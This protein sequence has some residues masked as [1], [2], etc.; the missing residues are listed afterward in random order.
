MSLPGLLKATVSLI[1]CIVVSGSMY[2]AALAAEPHE[3]P[4]TAKQAFNGVSLLQYY[5]D[6]LHFVSSK[7]PEEVK[8]RLD[9]IPFVN[10][11]L[12]MKES[13]D[14]FTAASLDLAW[15]LLDIDQNLSLMRQL[16]EEDSPVEVVSQGFRTYG[17]LVSAR[18][19]V[20]WATE[21]VDTTGRL[22]NV[23]S[24]PV[25]SDLRKTYDEVMGAVA[26]NVRETLDL[27]ES[28]LADMMLGTVSAEII[29]QILEEQEIDVDFTL[30]QP[31]ISHI[32]DEWN[33]AVDFQSSPEVLVETLEK[34]AATIDLSGVLTAESLLPTDVTLKIDRQAAYV[35]ENIHFEG[36]L[37]SE[38][39]ALA[40]RDIDILLNGFPWMTT[41]TETNGN[42]E[43]ILSVPY[44]Y[45][46]DVNV[47]VLFYP[48]GEDVNRYISSYSPEV[49]LGLLFYNTQL[50]VKVEDM[51][52]PGL[53]TTV[54]GEFD[55]GPSPPP[56]ERRAEIY[57]DDVLISEFDTGKEFSQNIRIPPELDAGEHV[58]TISAEATGRY[59]PVVAS[60]VLNITKVA[61]ILD[62]DTPTI[63]VVPGAIKL[64]GRIY[65]DLSPPTDTSII[66]E[67]NKSEVELNISQDGTFDT[68]IGVGMGLGL[69]GSQELTVRVIPQ[70]PWHRSFTARR[71]I[72]TINAVNCGAILVLLAVLGIL[73]P[74]ISRGRVRAP[75][76]MTISPEPDA[77]HEQQRESTTLAVF[78]ENNDGNEGDPRSRAFRWYL[79][80]VRLVQRVTGFLP[81]PQQTLREFARETS[82]VLGPTGKYFQELTGIVERL[83]YS[84]QTATE[85]DA[86]KSKQLCKGIEDGLEGDSG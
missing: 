10:I 9:K 13:A 77:Y 29:A 51:A 35:G 42:Y 39:E 79:L 14:D 58:L 33:V 80:A 27:N 45:F 8:A 5:A 63:L 69:I 56:E 6:A 15:L 30:L 3:D 4:E 19:R 74:R 81:R 85:E 25:E 11:P 47:Q 36:M 44:R 18:E 32:F 71:N 41:T 26:D 65:S 12:G 61:P 64:K 43:D 23:P 78:P 34:L 2:T 49:R 16:L 57:L 20:D 83:L 28:I 22:L 40:G 86:E 66:M 37:T 48:R 38:G 21:V 84:H 73:L 62:I 1:A 70:E 52:Y 50:E 75:S 76:A 7:Q 82:R 72:V 24:A 55:Y 17:K 46:P 68:R 31:V 54:T 60:T 67:F 53:K 59:S